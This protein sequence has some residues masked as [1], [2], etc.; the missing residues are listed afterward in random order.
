MH[1]ILSIAKNLF[2]EKEGKEILRPQL[3]MTGMA[4]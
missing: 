4:K 3:R 2:P 1:V